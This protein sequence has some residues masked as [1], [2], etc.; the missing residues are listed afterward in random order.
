M[1]TLNSFLEILNLRSAIKE[2]ADLATAIDHVAFKSFMLKEG[3]MKLRFK[4]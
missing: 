2:K 3:R 4:F 1:F